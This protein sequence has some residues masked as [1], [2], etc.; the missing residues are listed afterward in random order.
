ML[1]SWHGLLLS[2]SC[3]TSES[4]LD[5][6]SCGLFGIWVLHRLRSTFDHAWTLVGLWSAK[7][8]AQCG[9]RLRGVTRLSRVWQAYRRGHELLVVSR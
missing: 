2:S 1:G 5:G 6:S 3:P 9:L 8:K 7:W 4:S